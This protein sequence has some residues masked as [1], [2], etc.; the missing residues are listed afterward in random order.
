MI[1]VKVNYL[2]DQ[3]DEL[4]VKGHSNFAPKGSDIVCAGVSAIVIGGLNAIDSL[5]ENNNIDYEVS[6]GYVRM[7][8]LSNVEV[9]NILKIIIVQLKSVEDSYSKHI[10]IVESYQ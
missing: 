7:S 1:N 10:K 5:V 3:I 2:N 8:N 6:D 4:V 9:Q